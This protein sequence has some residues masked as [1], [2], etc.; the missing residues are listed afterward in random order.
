MDDN[1]EWNV[2]EYRKQRDNDPQIKQVMNRLVEAIEN[3]TK[4]MGRFQYVNE[5]WDPQPVAP[6]RLGEAHQIGNKSVLTHTYDQ[7]VGRNCVI[8]NPSEHRMRGWEKN[9]RPDTGRTERLCEHGVGH[10]DPDDVAYWLT[11]GK[12]QSSVTTHGCDGCCAAYE[13][14]DLPQ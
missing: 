9:Y 4:A 14:S 3:V 6:K 5:S 8:H 11:L 2:D 10:P 1:P 12:T 13:V 7:C